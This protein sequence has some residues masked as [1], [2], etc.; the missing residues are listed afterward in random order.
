MSHKVQ[1][2]WH[3]FAYSQGRVK[4]DEGKWLHVIHVYDLFAGC[5]GMSQGFVNARFLVKLV[6]INK[7]AIVTYTENLIKP[8]LHRRCQQLC[9]LV[10]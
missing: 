3:H 2:Q 8:H 4:H 6:D 7:V 9:F 10:P 5:C 1:E